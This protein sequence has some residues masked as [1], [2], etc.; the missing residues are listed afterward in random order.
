MTCERYYLVRGD[1]RT[2]VTSDTAPDDSDSPVPLPSIRGKPVY[3]WDG[4]RLGDAV[5]LVVDFD[6]GR[7][8]SLLVENVDA[9]RFPH[10]RIGE[11]GVRVPFGAVRSIADAV[12]VEAP[13]SRYVSGRTPPATS[14]TDESVA[15]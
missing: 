9:E 4:Y 7:T 13:L 10:L 12:V 2:D 5:D 6:A 14:A 8:T 3:G 15:E 11:R 1:T